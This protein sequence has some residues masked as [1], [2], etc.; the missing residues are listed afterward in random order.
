V[1]RSFDR[2][3]DSAQLAYG[4]AL[5]VPLRLAELLHSTLGPL[6]DQLAAEGHAWEPMVRRV[7]AEYTD[8]RNS[9]LRQGHG[10]SVLA[11][12]K[13]ET[14]LAAE[15]VCELT[16]LALDEACDFAAWAT[17]VSDETA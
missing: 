4:S 1:G 9:I 3:I 17:E 13:H 5:S 11:D 15:W 6:A 12:I 7:L 2:H 16:T 10:S 14:F 8:M